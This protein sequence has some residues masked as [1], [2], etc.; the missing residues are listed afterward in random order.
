MA[1]TLLGRHDPLASSTE[2]LRILD[3]TAGVLP[4]ET[5]LAEAGLSPLQATGITVFQLNVGKIGRAHV[6]TPVT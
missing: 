5:R 1:L 4:F 2:Q 6:R 3:A